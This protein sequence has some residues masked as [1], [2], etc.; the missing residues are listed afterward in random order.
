[1]QQQVKKAGGG[2]FFQALEKRG[3][4]FSKAWKTAWLALLLL[5]CGAPA[6]P[7]YS[8]TDTEPEKP[9][10]DMAQDEQEILRQQ[11]E[12]VNATQR[13]ELSVAMAD[14]RG[15][16]YSA[17][18]AALEKLIADDPAVMPAWDILGH[19]YLKANRRDDAFKL[20]DQLRA[21]RP[22]FFP[23][24]NWLGRAYMLRNEYVPAIE[25]YRTSLSLRPQQDRENTQ[26]N[27]ARML[28]WSGN[29][30]EAITRLR[31]FHEA[32][33]QRLDITRELASAL[34]SN[35][36]FEEALPLWT[37]LRTAEPTNL[38]FRAKEA[39]ALLHTGHAEE[40]VAQAREVLAEDAQQPDTL[41]LMANYAQFRS[42]QPETALPWL[43]RL[44]AQAS[45]FTLQR[46][47]TLRY[48]FLWVQ[49]SNLH[50]K[51]YPLALP[52]DLM[53]K[54]AQ[55][56]PYDMDVIMAYAELLR[57]NR[58]FDE[59]R[60][61][62]D[63]ALKELNPNSTRAQNNLFEIAIEQNK[64]SEAKEHLQ[65]LADF[66]PSNPFWH[67][68]KARWYGAQARYYDAQH[69]VDQLEAAG[70]RGAV[71]ILLY[72]GLS[73]SE[74]GEVMPAARLREHL[75]ALKQAGFRFITA[76]ELPDYFA[77]R[78]S[79]KEVLGASEVERVVCVT[80]DDAR[81]DTMRYATPVGKE[82]HLPFSMLVP[83][84][85]IEKKHPF[86]C[87][88]DMLRDYQEAGCWYFG[89]HTFYAHERVP[90]DAEKRLG[91]A[92]PN[93]IWLEQEKRLETDAEY[94]VRLTHEYTG[95]RDLIVQ[96]LGHSNECNF[97]A[98]PFG[99]IGQITRSNDREAPAKNLAHLARSYAVGFIQTGSGYAVAGDNPLLYQRYE[100][101]RSSSGEEVLTHILEQNPINLARRMR[102]EVAAMEDKRYLLLNSLRA[103]QKDGY[104]VKSLEMLRTKLESTLGR[105]IPLSEIES[106]SPTPAVNNSDDRRR[107][108]HKPLL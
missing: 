38:L 56:D 61:Q 59:A 71:A 4:D 88:W 45:T 29:L 72:H 96:N 24:Y 47:Y 41:L 92:L 106:A 25:A 70:R 49:M 90:I 68:L 54:I 84:G 60:A 103:L 81:R 13:H 2:N 39:V 89:G 31:P 33:P 105:R 79:L 52:V 94:D 27:L 46:L 23:V 28:R 63:R 12:A 93:H 6:D 65:R 77:K 86:M 36:E 8:G 100:P 108:L 11:M 50:P 17:A 58:Q 32:Y 10:M 15:G 104:P 87:T 78:A 74:N 22:D 85:F 21:L 53:G 95:C 43:E 66:N 51:Q 14:Y 76:H 42:G 57:G 5:P 55:A 20:W 80:F 30:V 82:L 40:A 73:A 9:A 64:F 97:F 7:E 19:A 102:A 44:I 67:Y 99:D 18:I 35:R 91:F 3:R 26:L 98:Y 101:D 62:L 75:L 83:V 48:V 69:E 1:M 34:I 37:T 16:R 107:D